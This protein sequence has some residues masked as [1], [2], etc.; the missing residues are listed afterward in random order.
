MS[1]GSQAGDLRFGR[2]VIQPG[3]RRLDIDGQPCAIGARAFDVLMVLVVERERVV[4]KAELL[5]RVWP[6]VVVEENN[7]QVHISALRKL[8]GPQA[9]VTIPGR[10][11]RF[12]VP[13][14]GN[15]AP[16]ADMPAAL[17]TMAAGAD[18]I[19]RAGNLPANAPRLVGRDTDIENLVTLVQSRP[20]VSIVGAG[21][22]GK[23]RLAQAVAHRLKDDF[24]DGV[25][26]VE[27]ASVAA[28]ELMTAAVAQ[29]LGAALTGSKPPTEELVDVLCRRDLLL[30]LDNC[31][32]VIDVAS[33][34]AEAMLAQA[35]N[36]RL[37]VTSQELLR[38]GGEQLFR[39]T[40]L[41][42]PDVPDL[43]A[44]R[45]AGAVGLFVERAAAV[46]PG[47]ALDAQN[48]ADIAD[49]CRRL[50]G[51]PLAIELAAARVPL[52]GVAGVRERLDERFRMLTGGAR[53]VLRRHQTL[54]ELLDWSH[55]LLGAD[56]RVVF[57]R[58]GGFVGSFSLPAAQH[59]FADA[60]LDEWAVLDHL[61]TLVGKSLLG[62]EPGEP[63][64]YRM[65]ESTRAYALEKLR[66]AGETE[67]VLR[68]HAEAL[69]AQFEHERAIYWS[70][71]TQVRIKRCLPDVDN[72][73][74]ALDWARNTGAR[75]LHVALAGA[76]AWVWYQNQLQLEGV[77]RCEEALADVDASTP[78]AVEARL[79]TEREL[80][81]HP[82]YGEAE[83]AALERALE[84]LRRIDD[85]Q[86]LFVALCRV[87]VMSSLNGEFEEAERA[88]AEM[89]RIHDPSWP[90]TLRWQLLRARIWLWSYDS[91]LE[92]ARV[93]TDAALRLAEESGDESH[94]ISALIH[95]E[96]F[97]QVEGRTEEAV[98]R[99]R[100]LIKLTRALLFS[101]PRAIAILNLGTALVE[102]GRLEEAI[103]YCRESVA[104]STRSGDLW[105]ELDPLALLALRQG[106]AA[107][108]ARV[109]GRADAA[110][111]WRKGR[112]EL[113][114]Q[115]IRD[116]VE[117]QLKLQLSA[118]EFGA[119]RAEGGS[120]TDE[121]AARIGFGD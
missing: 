101:H 55:G 91:R 86:G 65:L 12:T 51:L 81:A 80:C 121:A 120:L 105:S 113:G 9:I 37:L 7:L 74:A 42:V 85:R 27:L 64:R 25:W 19:P 92:A 97:A 119:L 47:F 6:G 68:R 106:R 98:E 59:A 62:V 71:P 18:A 50:D 22:I 88:L 69:C 4:S 28:P 32:H 67:A 2:A 60:Q 20:L 26:M 13:L 24:P 43:G 48:V 118:E 111:A 79:L 90:A 108:A 78:P 39:A 29:A 54:R 3:A 23:T 114:E 49:I 61:G 52:L 8:L 115:R 33:H 96:Q 10:G 110:H 82:R 57:R 53:T 83:R 100:E 107:D 15:A 63:P 46:Q 31:E 116:L 56:E 75:E 66:E 72:L 41:A 35:P 1:D 99:G 38:V 5:D 44:A 34:F 17:P 70:V 73:R 102:L 84:L 11:Y 40:P 104:L 36:V 103:P 76:S 77:R 16:P 95:A 21:G 87:T 94:K 58:A 117:A 30:V 112:R 89:E 45:A 93:Q 14:A 109:L